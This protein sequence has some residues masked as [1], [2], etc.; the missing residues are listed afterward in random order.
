MDTRLINEKLVSRKD[1]RVWF[2]DGQREYKGDCRSM[3]DN[4]FL[5]HLK[6]TSPLEGPLT[7]ARVHLLPVQRHL[8]GKTFTMELSSPKTKGEVKVAVEQVFIPSDKPDHFAVIVHFDV[9]PDPNFIK[10]LCQPSITE[11]PKKPGT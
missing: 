3:A 11:V 5:A 2:W 9:P 8:V 6:A 7:N 4:G 1:V 10:Y